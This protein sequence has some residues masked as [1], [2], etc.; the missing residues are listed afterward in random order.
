M[1]GIRGSGLDGNSERHLRNLDRLEAVATPFELPQATLR[2]LSD[3]VAERRVK[4]RDC[5]DCKNFVRDESGLNFGWCNAHDQF[6]K[7]YHPAGQWF[8]QCIFKGL[9][10]FKDQELEPARELAAIQAGSLIPDDGLD[11]HLVEG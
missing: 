10:R 11:V 5:R 9:R 6:I 4:V 1:S 7:L 3:V 2:P 8:S